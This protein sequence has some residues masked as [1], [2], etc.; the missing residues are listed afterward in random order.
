MVRFEGSSSRFSLA[1]ALVV[2]SAVPCAAASNQPPA[3]PFDAYVCGELLSDSAEF[4]LTMLDP[5]TGLPYDAVRCECRWP[6]NPFVCHS[7]GVVPQLPDA[8]INLFAQVSPADDVVHWSLVDDLPTGDDPSLLYALEIAFDLSGADLFGGLTWGATVDISRY[9]RVRIRY[10]TTSPD[11][12]F[13]LK[14]NS[15]LPGAVTEPWVHL[16]GSPADGSWREETFQIAA[17]F[18]GTDAAHLNSIVLATSQDLVAEPEPILWVDHLAFLADPA[19]AASCSVTTDCGGDPECYP[20]LSHYEPFTGAV[21]I[22]NALTALSLLPEVDHITIDEPEERVATILASLSATARVDNWMQDWYSPASLMPHPENRDGSLTDLAQLYAAL[23]VVEQTWPSLAATASDIRNGMLDLTDL[24]EHA[25]DGSC[26]GKLHSAMNMCEG[27][28]P[29]T[30]EHY[31]N[32]ALLGGVLAIATGAAP[33]TLWSECLSRKGC[34]LRGNGA[35]HWYTT[36]AFSCADSTIPAIETGGPFLQLAALIYL[37]A[38]QLPLGSMT[39][40]DSAANML[41][42]QRA[43]AISQGL[44]LWGWA[45]QGDPD[46]CSYLVCQQFTPDVVTPYISAMGL[47]LYDECAINLFN[48]NVY[49]AGEPFDSGTVL[50]RFGLLDGWNQTTGSGRLNNYLYLDT[51]WTVLGALNYC[52]DDL[53]RQRFAGHPV[54]VNGYALLGALGLPCRTSLPEPRTPST[55]LP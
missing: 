49:G 20:D 30:L 11:D 31:G 55:R 18:S 24:F 37:D 38:D 29:W 54:A 43:W 39:L 23:M 40:A 9:D 26:E 4:L 15:G 13:E 50:H 25:P 8:E 6:A 7:A 28:R 21:N 32:D 17:A 52:L 22:A 14:L 2:G 16:P 5:F 33:A 12:R 45:N 27:R 51:G 1:I 3:P 34:E 19:Q 47:E 41:R 42:A 35:Y 10:R 48:F 46:S 44:N 53:V 36:G